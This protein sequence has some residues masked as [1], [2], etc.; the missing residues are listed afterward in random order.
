MPD[1]LTLFYL[2][3]VCLA[4][5]V[6]GAVGWT[7]YETHRDHRR[8]RD[9]VLRKQKLAQP[10]P[11]DWRPLVPRRWRIEGNL[12]FAL[13]HWAE[14][15]NTFTRALTGIRRAS[16]TTQETMQR[17]SDQFAKAGWR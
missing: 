15:M 10:H 3:M 12:R 5:G 7:I 2:S 8:A 13:W 6:L 1:P 16:E 9:R 17:L 14:C 4:A 11:D